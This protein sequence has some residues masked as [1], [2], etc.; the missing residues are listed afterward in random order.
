MFAIGPRR[1][2]TGNEIQM[3]E[4]YETLEHTADI[5]IRAFGSTLEECMENAAYGMFDQMADLSSVEPVREYSLEVEGDDPAQLM[6][7]LLSELLY[8]H[9]TEF[10]LLSEFKVKY[11][12]EV[13]NLTARGEPVDKNRHEMRAAIKAVSYHAL[14]V[15]PDKGYATVLFDA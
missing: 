5:M 1:K 10:V 2:S 7:D 8:L 14:E 4:R 11:D 3:S 15:S 12:R 6:V 13:L 9:D